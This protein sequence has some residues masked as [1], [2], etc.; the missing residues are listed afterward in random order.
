MNKFIL[1]G[2]VSALYDN[3]TNVRIT[4]ADNYKDGTNFIPVTLFDKKAVF[5]RNNIKIGDHIYIDGSI[6]Y[7]EVV[8]P[9]TQEKTSKI[10]VQCWQI[11]FEGYKNPNA[12][13]A[14]QYGYKSTLL[15]DES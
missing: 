14:P 9:E 15:P 3:G 2:N 1:T 4:V 7:K 13:K 10:F 8:N 12:S 5:A 6:G 11:G